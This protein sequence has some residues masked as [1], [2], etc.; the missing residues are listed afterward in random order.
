MCL[1]L[2]LV[3]NIDDGRNTYRSVPDYVDNA[4]AQDGNQCYWGTVE[5]ALPNS[6]ELKSSARY[7]HVAVSDAPVRVKELKWK[8]LPS[9]LAHRGENIFREDAHNRQASPCSEG[10]V[11]EE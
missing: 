1:N 9:H 3:S 11:L 8:L 7:F 5:A 10:T 6:F 4:A 2:R